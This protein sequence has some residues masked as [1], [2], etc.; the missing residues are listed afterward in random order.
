MP[1]CCGGLECTR[2]RRAIGSRRSSFW[3][4]PTRSGAAAPANRRLDQLQLEVEL[5]RLYVLTE[6]YAD[7]AMLF[8]A[9]RPALEK[10]KDF[11]LDKEGL[12]SLIGEK[13]LIYELMGSAYLEVKRRRMPPRRLQSSTT[14]PRT[15]ASWR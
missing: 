9:V 12:Q 4:K 8:D 7:A 13:G 10:P 2:P 11:G 14:L 3:T 1:R 6:R 15:R 5:A